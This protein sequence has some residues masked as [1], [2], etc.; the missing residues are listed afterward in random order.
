MD[1][2]TLDRLRQTH[3]AWRLLAADHAPLIL[4]FLALAFIQPNRRAIPAP[5]L[6]ALLDA[7]LGQLGETHGTERYPKSARQYLE[8]WA[9]PERA[10][11][12][13]YYPKSGEDAEFD[14]TPA[15]EKAIE[16]IQ[17]LRPQQF[18]GTE[19]RLMTLFHLLR[20]LATGAQ[21]D[22][23]A[24]IQE[25][26][27]RRAELEREI[28]RV[29]SGQAGPLDATQVKERYL[30]VEDTA[31]HLLGD[32]R[33]VE[34]NFRGLDAQTRERVATSAQPKGALLEEIFGET[35]H[36]RRSDQGKSFDAFWEFLMSPARQ[37]ELQAWLARVHELAAVRELSH[38]EFVRNI[39]FL[40]L[41][42]GEKIHGTVAQLVEQLRRFV[43]DQAHLEN[44]RILDLIREIEAHAIRLRA[45]PPHQPAFAILDGLAPEFGLPLCRT[46]YRPPRNPMLDLGAIEEGEAELDLAAL[47]A[48]TAVDERLLREHVSELLRSRSQVTLAEVASAFPPERGLAEV[49]A[50]LR[51]AGNEGA[52]VDESVTE[53]LVI[54][55]NSERA[56][57]RVR[58]PRVIFTE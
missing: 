47:F 35:D 21:A 28:E 43:D 12:R 6:V 29:R 17:G 16:W 32:F 57:R 13:K 48:Q 10:Y 54:P 19:S 23:A 46:L 34:E 53:T 26:E 49:V 14:L 55:S 24:R 37:D 50:Y 44:R 9:S 18:V 33:Q 4:S 39:P 20:E 58:L 51:I 27:R 56:E 45:D 7:Y 52:A 42:A 3:A 22:P 30:Q 36:I 8:D 11:L 25:L 15:A 31:R 38:E 5:E 2:D 1:H 40:L 41:D